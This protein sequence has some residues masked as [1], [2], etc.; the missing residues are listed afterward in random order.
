M[1]PEAVGLLG[2]KLLVIPADVVALSSLQITS[3]LSAG[4][5]AV[6]CTGGL[7]FIL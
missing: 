3:L 2:K 1:E 5:R 7:K 6:T 4:T